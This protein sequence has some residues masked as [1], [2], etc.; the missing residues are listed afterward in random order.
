MRSGRRLALEDVAHMVPVDGVVV[1]I[2]QK[3]DPKRGTGLLSPD[4]QL[5]VASESD[6]LS[7]ESLTLPIQRADGAGAIVSDRLYDELVR[8]GLDVGA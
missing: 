7:L 8:V 3:R 2:D 6:Q 5:G 4:A 1:R